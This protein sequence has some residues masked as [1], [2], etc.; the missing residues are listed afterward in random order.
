[1][2]LAKVDETIPYLKTKKFDKYSIRVYGTIAQTYYQEADVSN[3]VYGYGGRPPSSYQ[4]RNTNDLFKAAVRTENA[5][6]QVNLLT[7]KGVKAYLAKCRSAIPLELYKKF[8]IDPDELK[9]LQ[10]QSGVMGIIALVFECEE[11]LYLYKVQGWKIDM[12]MPQYNLALDFYE[13]AAPPEQPQKEKEIKAELMCAYITVTPGCNVYDV[14][15]RI[16]TATK[17]PA[18]RRIPETKPAIAP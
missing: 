14:L 8:G 10:K 4:I 7:Q 9:Y 12:Y 1:M 3:I 18:I 17:T 6:R 13:T 2:E 16:H 5:K 11:K 15:R